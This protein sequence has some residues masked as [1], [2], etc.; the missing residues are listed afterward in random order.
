MQLHHKKD[1]PILKNILGNNPR[2]NPITRK[3]LLDSYEKS[4]SQWNG[5]VMYHKADDLYVF[6]PP[7]SEDEDWDDDEQY[8][9][10]V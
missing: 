7:F 5:E 1:A 6:E 9:R 4:S 3:A 8:Q 10:V 2:L